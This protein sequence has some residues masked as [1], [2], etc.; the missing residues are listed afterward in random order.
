MRVPFAT[1][2]DLVKRYLVLLNYAGILYRVILAKLIVTHLF[3][4]FSCDFRHRPSVALLSSLSSLF[5][6][7]GTNAR[8]ALIC[9]FTH[10]VRAVQPVNA[11]NPARPQRY[12]LYVAL[13]APYNRP[14][15]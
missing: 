14:P 15:L 7:Q 13:R 12:G 4:N 1:H 6:F 11:A 3:H 8:F 10:F 9:T 2:S 5:S